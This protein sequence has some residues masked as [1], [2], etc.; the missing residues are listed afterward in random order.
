MPDS[1]RISAIQLAKEL[2]IDYREGLVK[3]RYIGRTFI[4]PGQ[5]I[6]RDSVRKKLNT[7]EHEFS[8]KCVLLVDDSIVRGNTSRKIVEMARL[9]GAKKVYFASAAPPVRFPNV[10]GIDMAASS[11][12][13]AN[14][15]TIDEI[16]ERMGADK[17][18]YQDLEDLVES[19]NFEPTGP[20]DF[21]TSCFN[22]FYVTDNVSSEY[23][24]KIEK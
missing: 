24:E 4:M 10:Y 23:L 15:N 21:D 13:I 22:G 18:F 2:D 8:G 6:R 11:E 12:F 19:V 17:L 20:Q 7:V 3:N 14:K 16:A 5:S 1:G 9:S